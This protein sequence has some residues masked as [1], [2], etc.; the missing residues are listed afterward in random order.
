MSD[1]HGS[2]VAFQ[3]L[4]QKTAHLIY[5]IYVMH[6]HSILITFHNN[7]IYS[8]NVGPGELSWGDFGCLKERKGIILTPR[9]TGIFKYKFHHV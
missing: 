2:P 1:F 4:G 9:P 6:S 5:F 7:I 8:N 3:W